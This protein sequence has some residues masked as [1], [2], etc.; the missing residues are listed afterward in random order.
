[1]FCR[2]LVEGEIHTTLSEERLSIARRKGLV[3]LIIIAVVMALFFNAAA[4]GNGNRQNP[5]TITAGESLKKPITVERAP[6]NGTL[7]LHVVDY[8]SWQNIS[9]AYVVSVNQPLGQPMLNGSTNSTGYLTFVS[10][11]PGYYE[12]IVSKN[13]YINCSF[14][15]TVNG[16]STA[17]YEVS[18]QSLLCSAT[19]RLLETSSGNPIQGVAVVLTSLPPGQNRVNLTDYIGYVT[20]SSIPFGNYTI[21]FSKSG[22]VNYAMNVT[23]FPG[24]NP[25]Q[26]VTL[27]SQG[28]TVTGGP[29]EVLPIWSV[30]GI[31]GLIGVASMLVV[32]RRHSQSGHRTAPQQWR[33]YNIRGNVEEQ[34]RP[35]RPVS[36]QSTRVCTYCGTT[37]ET[38]RGDFCPNCGANTIAEGAAPPIPSEEKR[39]P[40]T[41][42]R[43]MVCNLEINKNEE[44]LWCP[45]CGNKAHKAHMLEWLHVKNYCPM[46]HRQLDE[47]NYR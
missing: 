40:R 37:I 44:A 47:H 34:E 7:L 18:L 26:I 17:R 41:V 11:V 16:T 31:L 22:Y 1:M 24:V 6:P 39:V 8:S 36:G 12:I 27:A 35:V 10:L 3:T 33:A 20:F 5:V 42:G 4:D 13:W 2:R 30:V 45:F 9:D 19:F 25:V 38:K 15:A 14:W 29:V 46:C 43:C 21:S 23:L 32:A 28:G